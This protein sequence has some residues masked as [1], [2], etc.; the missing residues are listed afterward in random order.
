MRDSIFE[1]MESFFKWVR[2]EELMVALDE[3]LHNEL[4]LERVVA[5]IYHQLLNKK[6]AESQI[7]IC[8]AGL[9][10]AEILE[11]SNK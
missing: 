4:I 8:K 6:P 7:I 3:I 1:T 2:M 5:E 11:L 10:K 9:S